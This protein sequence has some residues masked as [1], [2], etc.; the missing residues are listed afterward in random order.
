MDP[1]SMAGAGFFLPPRH[2]QSAI[3]GNTEMQF[4]P[5]AKRKTH[6]NRTRSKA[7]WDG[8]GND[9][10]GTRPSSFQCCRG[11]DLSRVFRYFDF[12]SGAGVVERLSRVAGRQADGGLGRILEFDGASVPSCRARDAWEQRIA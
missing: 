11:S 4:P 8:N 1:E 7:M 10:I 2:F 5:K 6:D 9:N 12:I 3:S